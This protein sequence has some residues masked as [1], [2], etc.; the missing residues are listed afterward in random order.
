MATLVLRD[1]CCFDPVAFAA[2][3][4]AQPDFGPK[5]RPRYVRVTAAMPTSPTNKIIKRTLVHE[6]Y[7]PD[8]I[9]GDP[10]WVRERGSS[11][12][13]AFGSAEAEGVRAALEEAGRGRFWDL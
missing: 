1:G 13:D 6:K 5:W 10:V 7:R 12:Y 8:R 9:G 4:D 2:W 11:G 3:L